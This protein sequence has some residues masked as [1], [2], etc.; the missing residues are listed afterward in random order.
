VF[1]NTLGQ[2]GRSAR[3]CV[4]TG[5]E[6]TYSSYADI[7]GIFT[8]GD[9]HVPKRVAT[10]EQEEGNILYGFRENFIFIVHD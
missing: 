6:I 1:T 5:G 3:K 7:E 2:E 8:S 4:G 10:P 9:S